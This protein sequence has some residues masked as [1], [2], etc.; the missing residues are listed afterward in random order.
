MCPN[1]FGP[2]VLIWRDCITPKD[3]LKRGLMQASGFYIG[4][5]SILILMSVGL[6]PSPVAFVRLPR[7]YYSLIT[8]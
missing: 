6:K 4:T 5:G 7:L 2:D 1:R 3:Y 8:Y